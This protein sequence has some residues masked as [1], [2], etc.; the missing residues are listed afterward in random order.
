MN[1]KNKCK[2]CKELQAMKLK[3]E[4]AKA[5]L[6]IIHAWADFFSKHVN[7]PKQ[8]RELCELTLKEINRNA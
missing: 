4:S 1:L 5:S 7:N 6:Q 8:I 2:H 3:F